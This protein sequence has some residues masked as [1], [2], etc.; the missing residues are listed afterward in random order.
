LDFKGCLKNEINVALNKIMDKEFDLGISQVLFKPHG[1]ASF[2]QNVS[3][4][5]VNSYFMPN[6]FTDAVELDVV[7]KAM[8]PTRFYYREFSD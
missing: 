4:D 1:K 2:D 3:D 6:K 5:H 7:E 8:L